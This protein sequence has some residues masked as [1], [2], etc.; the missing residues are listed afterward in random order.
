M[1]QGKGDEGAYIFRMFDEWM[2]EAL[3]SNVLAAL[4]A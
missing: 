3:D 1:G 2:Q 4:R